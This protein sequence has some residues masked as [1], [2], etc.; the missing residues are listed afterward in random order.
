[1]EIILLLIY[2]GIV[3]LIFFKFKWLPWNFV[4]QVIVVTIPIIGLTLLI[5]LLNIVAPSSS[6]V[7]VI[8]YVV[9]VIPR[10]IGR[11]VSVPVEANR[12]I[13]KGDVLFSVDPTPYRE[14]LAQLRAQ[15]PELVAKLASAEAYQRE[16][17]A[18]LRSARAGEASIH[19][20]LQLAK[21]R[22][23]QTHDLART[24]AGPTFDF[25]QAQ[26][27]ARALE[28]DLANNSANVSQVQQKLSATT[29]QGELS[30]VA[31]ARAALEQLRAQIQ[32][33]QW[34]L[35]ESTVYAPADGTI[36]NLQLREGS[37]ASNLPLAPVMTFV[38]NEQWVIAM[39][40]QNEL[41]YIKPG[42]EAEI[43]LKTFPNRIIKCKVDSIVWASGTGQLPLGGMVPPSSQ[44]PVPG[45][46]AQM[47]GAA[48]PARYAVRLMPVGRD[49]HAFLPMGAAGQGA[50]YTDKIALIQIVR[51]I[52]LRVSTKLDW[53]V[54][55]LH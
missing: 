47:T 44:A 31:Q 52:I 30:E 17:G 40:S 39:Y 51:R 55:K 45:M 18:Q 9:Q 33:A 5:L 35:K 7:R 37:Y 23:G 27:D 50:I 4:S 53:L 24:G 49:A 22:V 10:T 41:R 32:K 36:V 48:G 15:E 28:A 14:D 8:N 26:A 11:V 1:M 42:D 6:D 34:M 19:A 21:M 13:K 20:K 12:P 46:P 3:W 38:E 29:K 54:L 16:L 2:S 25:E 43:T